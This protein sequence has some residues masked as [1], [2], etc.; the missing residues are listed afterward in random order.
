MANI[1]NSR[2]IIKRSSTP[3]DVPTV[4]PSNDHTDGT[5]T[6][7]DIY[8]GEF[9]INEPDSK[10]FFAA[11]GSIVSVMLPASSA[12]ITPCPFGAKSDGLGEFLV[13]NGK[14][15][16]ADSASKTKT[17]QPIPAT[18]TITNISYQT[19]DGDTTTTLKIHIDGV[20]EETVTLV[21]M[22]GNG[23][24]VESLS[25]AVTAGQWAEIEYDANQK[26]GECTMNLLIEL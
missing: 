24:G 25:I 19:K 9:F 17:R 1:Q 10:L 11:D 3:G 22:N 13:A 15:T 4:G 5:W 2:L 7:L 23:S 12:K 8:N 14:S 18:G 16:D 21:N 20:V 26:P 6:D